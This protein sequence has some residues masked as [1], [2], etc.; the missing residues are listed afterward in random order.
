MREDL[1]HEVPG[2]ISH[3]G[4]LMMMIVIIIIGQ[5]SVE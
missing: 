5:I 2:K 4:L 1:L 3:R